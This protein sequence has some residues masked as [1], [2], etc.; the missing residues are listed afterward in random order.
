[1]GVGTDGLRCGL[2]GCTFGLFGVAADIAFTLATGKYCCNF[3]PRMEGLISI[4]GSFVFVCCISGGISP[5]Q[6]VAWTQ[7]LT[8]YA[9]YPTCLLT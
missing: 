9:A 3:V 5:H 7:Y 1:M 6:V 4:C 8:P 2:I